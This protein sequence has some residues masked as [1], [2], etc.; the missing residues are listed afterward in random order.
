VCY[1]VGMNSKTSLALFAG[2]GGILGA[3]VWLL[4][5][6]KKPSENT[7]KIPTPNEPPDIEPQKD[8]DEKL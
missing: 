5:F 1:G 3:V 8:D 6:A 7:E 4:F 2:C